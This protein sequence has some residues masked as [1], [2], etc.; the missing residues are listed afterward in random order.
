MVHAKSVQG[1]PRVL[2]AVASKHGATQEIAEKIWRVLGEKGINADFKKIDAS[3]DIHDY[4]AFVLGSAVYVG[5]WLD[6]AKKFIQ[7]NS[8]DLS[9]KTVW[10]FSSGPVGTPA[11]P[12]EEKS[13]QVSDI[14]MA[15]KAKEHRIFNG[16]ID[17]SRLNYGEKAILLA[18]GTKEGDY[19]NWPEI[20]AWA[21]SIAKYVKEEL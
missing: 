17:K 2:V 15:T 18:F 1:G 4:D 11:K 7:L 8:K 6:Q 3:T 14:I 13:V 10:L 19:R 16:K 12:T 20:S 21:E 9:K 5:S